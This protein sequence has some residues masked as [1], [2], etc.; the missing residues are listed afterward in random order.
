M[1]IKNIIAS[2]VLAIVAIIGLT[3]G[4]G[5]WYTVDE[6]ERA[7]T[8]SY[9]KVSGSAEP[10]FHFKMPFVE[11]IERVS[12]R[13]HTVRFD[14]VEAYSRDQQPATLAISVT[15]RIPADSVES[16][17][18]MYGNR[19][20][21]QGRVIDRKL[22]DE[23]K[24]VFGQY[25][26]I[27]AIQERASLVIGINEALRKSVE[28]QPVIIDSVQVEEIAFSDAY[29]QSVEQRMKAEV[30]VFTREQNLKTEK[31]NADIAVTQAK[32]RADSAL[33]EAEAQAKAIKLKGEA[34]AQAI[35]E[36]GDALRQNSQLVDLIAAERWDGSL[37]ATMVP[38][39]ALPFVNVR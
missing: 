23:V 6:G 15:Y 4:L 30:E 16:L 39:G 32:G 10:G 27:R 9:G 3:I 31:I 18:T 8:L 2:V 13:A 5:S 37:P 1:Q 17:Y 33:A 21:M 11:T 36:R 14:T 25:T 19:Q 12:V 35:R 22:P 7:V 24:N 20:N 38:N 34:E 28:G 29:E 26:A